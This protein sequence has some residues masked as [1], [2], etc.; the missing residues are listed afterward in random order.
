MQPFITAF[1]SW[2]L[3]KDE[4]EQR[5]K[6]MYVKSLFYM[7]LIVL[8]VCNFFFGNTVSEIKNFFGDTILKYLSLFLTIGLQFFTVLTVISFILFAIS[9]LL[10]Y[11]HD[12]IIE[13]EKDYKFMK[14]IKDIHLGNL[15]YGSF[16]RFKCSLED[17]MIF[18]IA[19]YLLDYDVFIQYK[20]IYNESLWILLLIVMF[21][22]FTIFSLGGIINRFFKLR[23]ILEEEFLSSNSKNQNI[24]GELSSLNS[25][26]QNID[27]ELISLRT[28]NQNLEKEILSIKVEN[29]K[30]RDKL[31][32][33]EQQKSSKGYI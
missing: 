21:L 8:S 2:F 28:M 32:T 5:F 19:A 20:S 22:A 1:S 11:I 15:I 6:I 4:N 13:I 3:N 25:G 17:I 10:D 31:L 27:G 26:N 29:R 12:K 24:D 23:D 30:L 7:I 33:L 9:A 16:D 18:L 14:R